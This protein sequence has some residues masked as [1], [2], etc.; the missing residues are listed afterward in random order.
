M[1]PIPQRIRIALIQERRR[2]GLGHGEWMHRK[3]LLDKPAHFSY[4]RRSAERLKGLASTMTPL[5][6][7]LLVAGLA[8]A[9]LG[10]AGRIKAAQL[11]RPLYPDGPHKPRN[12]L[13]EARRLYE[14]P[15]HG[16][17]VIN[18]QKNSIR[19]IVTGASMCLV[20]LVLIL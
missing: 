11:V 18:L 7:V 17:Y 19:L 16:R 3:S 12:V 10:I 13:Y 4:D 8:F 6:I 20:G 14:L 5:G 15:D 9:G 2:C 1:V